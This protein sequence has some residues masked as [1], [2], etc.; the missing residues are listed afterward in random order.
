MYLNVRFEEPGVGVEVDFGGSEP[1]APQCDAVHDNFHIICTA[2]K[3]ESLFGIV[4]D[5]LGA[6]NLGS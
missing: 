5:R 3:A 6:G 2:S 4:Y 1:P